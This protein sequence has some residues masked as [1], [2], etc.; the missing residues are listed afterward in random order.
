MPDKRPDSDYRQEA[1]NKILAS[2]RGMTEAV[3]AAAQEAADKGTLSQEEADE[4]A[5]HGRTLAG[6]L[7]GSA[8][9]AGGG[10]P[11]DAPAQAPRRGLRQWLRKLL[12]RGGTETPVARADP[13]PRPERS[14][15]ECAKRLSDLA[16]RVGTAHAATAGATLQNLQMIVAR[17]I[18]EIAKCPSEAELNKYPDLFERMLE[19]SL[20]VFRATG[21]VSHTN[22]AR[23]MVEIGLEA[24]EIRRAELRAAGTATPA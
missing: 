17:F 3:G 16:S 14:I 19:S 13:T 5:G 20:G 11:T 7:E 4:L 2:F 9:A 6:E 10:E 23:K 8:R 1:V 22:C 24:V 21:A 12:G 15:A 18:D